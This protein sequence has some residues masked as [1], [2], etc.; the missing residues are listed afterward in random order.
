MSG[1]GKEVVLI[2]DDSLMMSRTAG[3]Y[4]RA[5]LKKLDLSYEVVEAGTSDD[6]LKVLREQNVVIALMDNN[7]LVTDTRKGVDVVH[8]HKRMFPESET[9]FVGLSTDFCP[10]D[11]GYSLEAHLKARELGMDDFFSTKPIDPAKAVEMIERHSTPSSSVRDD[12]SSSV[13]HDGSVTSFVAG[14]R[15]SSLAVINE[16]GSGTGGSDLNVEGLVTGKAMLPMLELQQTI[17]IAGSTSGA[18]TEVRNVLGDR[19]SSEIFR[20]LQP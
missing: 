12:A 17:N 15:M 14:A 6:A 19:L 10:D 8:E 2:L 4:T 18:T 20:K 1:D 5:A 9:V 16:G 13:T 11:P 7:L 3:A